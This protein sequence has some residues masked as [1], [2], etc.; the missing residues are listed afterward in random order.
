MLYLRAIFFIGEELIFLP[1][2]LFLS[3][4]VITPITLKSFLIRIL[5]DGTANSGVPINIIDFLFTYSKSLYS[6]YF[7]LF[8]LY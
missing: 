1:L 2:P 3:V 6:K 7:F 4:A 5:R 8:A